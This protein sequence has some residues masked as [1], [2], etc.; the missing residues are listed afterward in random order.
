MILAVTVAVAVVTSR[1][2][3]ASGAETVDPT[4]TDTM[5]EKTEVTEVAGEAVVT[6]TV[7]RARMRI[8]LAVPMRRTSGAAHQH[9]E[10]CNYSH[11]FY[12]SSAALLLL[13]LHVCN[14][15][16]DVDNCAVFRVVV[17]FVLFNIYL[18]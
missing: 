16:D 15:E 6:G 12:R 8:C 17:I 11:K 2:I 3:L 7:I 14:K 18:H 13:M 9:P 5:T 4:P 10:V 1:A